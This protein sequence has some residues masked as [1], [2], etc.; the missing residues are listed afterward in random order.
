MKITDDIIDPYERI[1]HLE[2]EV[3]ELWFVNQELAKQLKAANQLGTQVTEHM[4][5]LARGFEQLYKMLQN[6]EFRTQVLEIKTN[7]KTSSRT[8]R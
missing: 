3:L 8:I 4:T 1:N 5:E 7:E 2:T 6:V